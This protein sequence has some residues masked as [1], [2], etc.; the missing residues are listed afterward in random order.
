MGVYLFVVVHVHYQGVGRSLCCEMSL[1]WFKSGLMPHL[2]FDS[3]T[4]KATNNFQAQPETQYV[5]RVQYII[6]SFI[7]GHITFIFV[8]CTFRR[9]IIS[10]SSRT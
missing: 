3:S 9:I 6:Y 8:F 1:G 7:Y 4:T 10:P 2:S 5:A